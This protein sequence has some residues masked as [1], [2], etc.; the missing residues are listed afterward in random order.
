MLIL[1]RKLNVKNRGQAGDTLIEVLLAMTLMSVVAI[2]SITLMNRGTAASQIS[3]ETTIAR[4]EIE[5]QVERLRYLSDMA[6]NEPGSPEGNQWGIL[7]TQFASTGTNVTASPTNFG[8]CP[9]NFNGEKAKKVRFFLDRGD[10]ASGYAITPRPYND[11]TA[12]IIPEA[13]KG[14]WVEATRERNTDNYTDF[15]VRACWRQ[16]SDK[17]PDLTLGTVV[18]IYDQP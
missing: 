2:S 16:P 14:I 9:P 12:E 17:G 18:R 5:S 4:Q 3:S 1:G 8:Y 10:A 6:V 7:K 11:T 15:H 13:G